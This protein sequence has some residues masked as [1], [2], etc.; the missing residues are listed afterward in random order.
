MTAEVE[1]MFSAREVPWHG[2]GEIVDGVLTAAEA[3]KAAKLDWNVKLHPVKAYMG[4]NARPQYV[5]IPDRSAVVRDVDNA[6][7][8][9]VGSDYVPFQNRDAFR[10]FDNIV[11]SGEAKYETAGSLRSGRW[12]WLT[13]KMPDGVLIGGVD[14]H[15]TYLLIS[16]SHDGSRAITVAVTPVRVVC[17]NTLNFALR[18]AKRRWTVRHIATAG[19]RLG[20]A[21]DAIGLTFKY[22]E[23]FESQ[24]EKLLG[25]SFSDKDMDRFLEELLPDRPRKE[26][27]KTTITDAFM[28]GENLENVRGTRWA[29]IN[30]VGEYM[31]WLRDPRTAESQVI[32]IWDGA[33]MRVKDKAL[34]LLLA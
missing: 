14:P 2:L 4:S 22:M 23:E 1:T 28:E 17:Q 12:V 29:A 26:K 9:I 21:R 31:D 32:G 27:V 6:T 11:D 3:L 19:Q 15:E 7:L 5:T 10:F 20:E 30:A 25:L 16:T 18:G 34:K 13:A 8:G 33:A 24:A